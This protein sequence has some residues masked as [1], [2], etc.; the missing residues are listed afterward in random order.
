MPT[1]TLDQL[2]AGAAR[3]AQS[4]AAA[5][6]TNLGL[7]EFFSIIISA[8]LIAGIVILIIKTN[9][10]GIKVERFRHIVLK[11][12]LSKE[13]AQKTWAKIEEHFFKG[14]EN[15]LKIAIIDADKLLGE[16]LREAGIRGATIGDR[17]KNV[18]PNQIPN[19]DQLWQAHRVRNDIAHQPTFAL[20]RDLAE[21]TLAIY[22]ETFRQ[23]ELID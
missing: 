21:K 23:F 12:D 22:E 14:G 18:R 3:A 7:L 2:N 9:W 4:L 8:A 20:K 11:T 17:L 5:Y 1:S 13:H 16:A 19:L 15:D 6:A 10:L